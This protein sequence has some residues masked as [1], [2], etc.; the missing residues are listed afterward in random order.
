MNKS[1]NTYIEQ[2]YHITLF[3]PEMPVL[4]TL[5]APRV[6]LDSLRTTL[7]PTQK[8]LAIESALQDIILDPTPES[9]N[10]DEEAESA[11]SY[12]LIDEA[13]HIVLEPHSTFL[14]IGDSMM[15]GVGMTLGRELKKLGF[16]V[17]DIAKQST[18][19]T[20]SSFF[21]WGKTLKEAFAK[22]PH[23][24]VVVVMVGAN[25]PY[26]MPKIKYGSEEWAETYSARIQEILDTAIANKA[27]VA[28]YEA[29]IVKKEPL[30]TRLAFLNTLYKDRIEQAKQVFLLSNLA[31]APDGI[32]TSY[33]KN[34]QG[35]S[36]KM[37]ATDG[38]HF[39]GDGSRA[40]GAL[41]LDRLL[42]IQDDPQVENDE[43]SEHILQNANPSQTILQDTKSNSNTKQNSL[44]DLFAEESDPESSTQNDVD[45]NTQ[46]L[47]EH[48][49]NQD[50]Q[51]QEIQ[52][53]SY[54]MPR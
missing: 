11:P 54:F 33:V 34:A 28:W 23:I 3:D 4:S 8:D 49:F 37:R 40:L 29:P 12:P 41:L 32:Y 13:G 31:L 16:N 2:K 1:I 47:Q 45:S 46:T 14:F 24:K 50:P 18:G 53:P 20:Y 51:H 10:L 48:I 43:E 21:D 30:N 26:S 5:G 39:S 17:I 36:V 25:D 35:K 7:F 19:L 22:N 52:L 15:Q 9:K 42:I 6:W 38:I 27:V 44:L